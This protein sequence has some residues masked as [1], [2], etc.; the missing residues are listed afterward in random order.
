M[1][2]VGVGIE[3]LNGLKDFNKQK[4]PQRKDLLKMQG[5]DWDAIS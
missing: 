2:E 5:F 1:S 3:K 4:L